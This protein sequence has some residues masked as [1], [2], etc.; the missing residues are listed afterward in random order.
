MI[1][2]VSY[3]RYKREVLGHYVDADWYYWYQCVDLIRDYCQKAFWFRMWRLP[4]AKMADN[5]TTFPW[6]IMWSWNSWDKMKKWDIGVTGG[7]KDG[8]IF[9]VDRL[10]PDWFRMLEQNGIWW[11][12][13]REGNQIRLRK[14]KRWNPPLL[15][16]FRYPW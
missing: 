9:I 1:N 6:W 13:K 14:C 2:A 8:H 3:I 15:C 10:E 4:S 7:T 11:W 16:Y 5:I 12:K